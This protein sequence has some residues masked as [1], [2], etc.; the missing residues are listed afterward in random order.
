MS[1]AVCRCPEMRDLAPSS[2]I[3]TRPLACACCGTALRLTCDGCGTTVATE[4]RR[5]II[6]GT[7]AKTRA[8]NEGNRANGH[9]I[10]GKSVENHFTE[11]PA[12]ATKRLNFRPKACAKC[13]EI[14]T[15]TGGR[16]TWCP[17]CKGGGG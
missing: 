10:G 5:V 9:A 4:E 17:A 13:G 12:H 8:P 15:P 3:P 16:D 6:D 7:V 2:P 1:A 11:A 14:F